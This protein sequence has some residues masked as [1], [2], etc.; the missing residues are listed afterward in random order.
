[1]RPTTQIAQEDLHPVVS[2]STILIQ[3][4]PSR[5]YINDFEFMVNL[6]N[7]FFL[8]IMRISINE[9]EIDKLIASQKVIKTFGKQIPNR[10]I[11]M[12]NNKRKYFPYELIL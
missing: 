11:L 7:S 10:Y 2:A 6:V 3:Q 8:A 9:N 4:R 12:M 1:M 5:Y